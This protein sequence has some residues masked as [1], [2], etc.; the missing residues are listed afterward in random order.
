[1]K[2]EAVGAGDDADVWNGVAVEFGSERSSTLT[3]RCKRRDSVKNLACSDYS[4]Q[5]IACGL[6]ETACLLAIGFRRFLRLA[7]DAVGADPSEGYVHN[8]MIS[9]G[10]EQ[11]DPE[12]GAILDLL[13][14]TYRELSSE[15]RR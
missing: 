4:C 5:R 12:R 6:R 7:C 14:N 3:G 13:H 9:F 1:M 15:T 10:H 8:L 2:I 11:A